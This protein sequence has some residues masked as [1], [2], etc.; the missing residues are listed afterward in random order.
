MS[1]RK[2]LIDRLYT[3]YVG[4]VKPGEAEKKKTPH[5]Q[6]MAQ[7]FGEELLALAAGARDCSKHPEHVQGVCPLCR[8]LWPEEQDA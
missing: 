8:G 1:N 4:R 7:L 2:L 3:S 5:L 6:S